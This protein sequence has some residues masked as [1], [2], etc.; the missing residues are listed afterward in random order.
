MLDLI[1]TNSVKV[2]L[3]KCVSALNNLAA[4]LVDE[5]MFAIWG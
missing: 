1:I 3:D 2:K 5:N 4:A